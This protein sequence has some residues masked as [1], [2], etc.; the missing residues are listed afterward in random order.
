MIV[1][2]SYVD[3]YIQELKKRHI[4]NY[5]LSNTWKRFLKKM[6][7]THFLKTYIYK[8]ARKIR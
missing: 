2:K 5:L 7:V 1:P 6:M 4:G 8:V 3:F